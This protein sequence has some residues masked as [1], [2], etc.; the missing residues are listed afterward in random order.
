MA[1]QSVNPAQALELDKHRPA[2]F[3]YAMLQ[4]RNESHADDVVQEALI[5][6]L[7]GA[8]RFSGGSSVRTWLIGILKHKIIDHFRRTSREQPLQLGSEETTCDDFDVMFKQDGHFVD[9]PE[10]W[11]NP[12]D[13]L[14]EKKFFE[15]LE[16]CMQGLPKN[17]A[18]A[19]MMRE[20]MGHDTADICKELSITENNCWVVLYRARMTLRLCLQERWFGAG[21]GG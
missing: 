18:R 13:A 17:T 1:T 15:V 10:A 8:A 4:L 19:V 12:E 7:Q 14:S 11:A 9:E 21:A 2:L 3:K 6:A 20:V 5:A 16:R